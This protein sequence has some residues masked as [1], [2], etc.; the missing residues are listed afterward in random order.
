MHTGDVKAEFQ[1]GPLVLE[2]NWAA[3]DSDENNPCSLIGV[4]IAS[5]AREGAAGAARLKGA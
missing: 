4:L 2:P 1:A 3:P 5:D